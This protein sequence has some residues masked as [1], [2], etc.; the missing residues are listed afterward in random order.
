[1]DRFFLGLAGVYGALAVGMGAFGAHA[2]KARLAELPDAVE[3]LGWWQ[4][5][6]TYHLIHA[7]AIGLAAW[8]ISAFP[9]RA[10]VVAAWLFAGGILIFSG[11]LYA[12][13]LSGARWLGA[14]T[15]FGGSMLI[16]G[17]VAIAWA[18]WRG[19]AG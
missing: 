6:A 8:A 4:T 13:T 12:M 9:G 10:N 3:R 18:A 7:L 11:S 15:P 14:M 5:A 2:L 1:M 17:W 16:A 19:A